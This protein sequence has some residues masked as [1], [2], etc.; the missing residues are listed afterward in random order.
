MEVPCTVILKP[1]EVLMGDTIR[2]GGY[3]N[4]IVDGIKVKSLD[5]N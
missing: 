3:R 5:E 1:M 4:T 2:L